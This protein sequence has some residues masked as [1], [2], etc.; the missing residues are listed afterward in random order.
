MNYRERSL[1]N[2]VVFLLPSLKL[3]EPSPAG[4]SIEN[5]L[6]GFLMDNFGGYT[7]QAGNIFG[8]WREGDGRDSY[9]EHREFSVAAPDSAKLPLLKQFLAQLARDLNEDCIYFRTGYEASLIYP[10][11]GTEA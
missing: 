9:G 10:A 3:K 2:A 11:E 1:G 4:P 5:R 6:H 8:Y 7:A